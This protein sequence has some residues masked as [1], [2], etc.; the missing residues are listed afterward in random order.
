QSDLSIQIELGV[1]FGKTL[2]VEDVNEIE[3]WLVPLLKREI[4]TQGPRKIVR[5]ADKQVDMH[6]DFRLYLCSRNE[7]IEIPPQR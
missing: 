1:R 4:A 7:N 2:I 3:G 6:D 5:I